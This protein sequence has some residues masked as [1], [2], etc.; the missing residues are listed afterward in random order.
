MATGQVG[1]PEI[2]DEAVFSST[3]QL[4]TF[5]T[6]MTSILANVQWPLRALSERAFQHLH[7]RW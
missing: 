4:S 3:F 2:R 5:A 7:I 1:P 6:E